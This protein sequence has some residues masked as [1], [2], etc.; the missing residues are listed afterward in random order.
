M[1]R[2]SAVILLCQATAEEILDMLPEERLEA[3]GF[4]V[5]FDALVHLLSGPRCLTN[6]LLERAKQGPGKTIWRTARTLRRIFLFRT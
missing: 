2:M 6:Y 4:L 1:N 5:G 3:F